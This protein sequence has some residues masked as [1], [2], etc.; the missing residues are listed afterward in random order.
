MGQRW[1]VNL[2][3]FLHFDNSRV[4][5]YE[6]NV[7]I[8]SWNVKSILDYLEV[9]PSHKFC[10]DQVT[11]L[12]GFKRLF[13]NY[14]DSLHQRVL[15]GRIEIVGGMYVMPD[16]I[17][18]DGE[19]I[20]RQFMFGT[21]FVREELGV[22][23]KTGWA[24]DSSGHCS[25]MPQ[26]LRQCGIDSYVFWRG[27]PYDS[28]TEFVWK[29]PDG[30]RVNAVW[31]SNGYDSSAWLSENLREAYSNLLKVAELAGAKASSQNVLVPVGGELVPP[32]P[33]LADI[34]S[35]WNETFPDMRMSIVTPREFTEK[36]K[37]VQA[38][39]PMMSGELASGRFSSARSGGLSARVKLKQM[40]RQL[41]SMLYLTELH[42][43]YTGDLSNTRVLENL[44]L[45]LL[46]NQDHNII[47]GTIADE[48]YQFAERRFKQA[49]DQA[50]EI[51]ED[52]ISGVA[53]QISVDPSKASFVIFNPLPWRRSDL[54]R[55]SIDLSKI[56]TPFFR[57]HDSNGNSVPYQVVGDI[58]EG[59]PAD[60][61]I[62]ASDMPSLGYRVYTIEPSEKP[63]EFE[64]SLRTG[65]NWIESDDFIVE[66]DDFSGA[67]T[68]V[69]DKRNQFEALRGPGNYLTMES[70]VGDL[71]RYARS[72]LSDEE[73]DLTTLRHSGKLSV[74]ESGPLRATVIVEGDF[75]DSK[76]VQRV[77]LYED[78]HR[79]DL[80]TELNFNGHGKRVR[81]NFPLTVLADNVV[82]GSQFGAESKTATPNDPQ[83]WA[84][85]NQ[86]LFSGLDW[87]DC[88][89]PE[90]GIGLSAFGLH[91]FHFRDGMLSV[92]L[93]R[94]VEQLSHGRHDDVLQSKTANE[95]G[96]HSFRMS[97]I[98]HKGTWKQASVWKT[99]AE[100]RLPLI[101]Y[102]LETSGGTL[103]LENSFLKIEGME[104]GLSCFK[105]GTS[106]HEFIIRLYE[107]AGEKGSA[108]LEFPFGV[109]RVSLVDLRENVIGDLPTS[110]ST[111]TIPVDAHSIITLRV[112]KASR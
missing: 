21:R 26:I 70:D 104:L 87:V 1:I 6:H 106:E 39:L 17:I 67:M 3:P 52:A 36:I 88:S 112:T 18:P 56:H 14:W 59:S 29:G 108:T 23:V 76:R 51:L 81:V 79:I 83:E 13:P 50:G 11:L 99:A 94:S 32:L 42:L 2:C 28:P 5:T 49:L 71:Y 103:P 110:G 38:S 85:A 89:G 40:N 77:V 8:V 80:E 66:F 68:R 12:E 62:L 33:H 47:R 31:L 46:F 69:F 24:I 19:S 41:E 35:H 98:P 58:A 61:L 25:Q 75:K 10:V 16:L 60:V 73:S 90:F 111:A 91:E 86:G 53:S 55:L 65:N 34:V 37:A 100:H 96:E 97:I 22:E 15:E 101:G 64:S 93:L 107:M 9:N 43:S 74:V 48:P 27:M 92:T 95:K 20:V 7:S 57:I 84:D 82:V 45:I 102:P 105:I 4:Q 72:T 109:S 44:W 54:T 63:L 30:S 78:L